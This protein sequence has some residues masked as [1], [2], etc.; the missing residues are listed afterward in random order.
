MREQ[1]HD[2][3]TT[4]EVAA[5]YRRPVPTI[6]Y[7]RHLGYGPKGIKMGRRVVYARAEI[8]RFDRQLAQEAGAATAA[9]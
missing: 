7:W 8:E 3:L 9:P 1:D 5:R 2:Y 6:R 4:E